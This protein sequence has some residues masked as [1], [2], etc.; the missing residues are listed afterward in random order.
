VLLVGCIPASAVC[1]LYLLGITMAVM[2]M[3]GSGVPSMHG[4]H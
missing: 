2:T 3:D 4:K 1:M